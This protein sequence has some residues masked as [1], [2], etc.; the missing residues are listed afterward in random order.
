[1]FSEK[2]SRRLDVRRLMFDPLNEQ[3]ADALM[4]IA[5]RLA[6]HPFLTQYAPPAT[7]STTPVGEA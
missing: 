4:T 2:V 5:P 1:M 6:D 3:L 7:D